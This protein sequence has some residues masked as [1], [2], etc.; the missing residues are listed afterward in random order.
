MSSVIPDG[1]SR[2]QIGDI[3]TFFGGLTGKT[4]RDFG[5]GHPFLTYMQ[6][7]SQQTSDKEA[8]D[9]VCINEGEKQN[10]VA[11]GDILFTTSSET[12]DEIGMTDVFLEINQTPYLNSFCFGLRPIMPSSIDPIFAKYLFRG[13]GFREDI[14]PLA[15]GSTRFNFSK[16]NLAK[17]SLLIPSLP[18]QKEIASILVSV[19]NVIENAQKKINKLQDLK[20]ATMNELLIKGI[21]HT[22]FKDSH[23]GMIPKSWEV[24]SIGEVAANVTDK[25]LPSDDDSMVMKYIGLE[26]IHSETNRILEIGSSTDVIS[27]K[28]IF[29]EGDTLFGKLRPYLKKVVIAEFSGICSTD[30]LSIRPKINIQ[31]QFLFRVLSSDNTVAFAMQGA[32]GNIMPRTSWKQLKKLRFGL[33]S[34]SEQQRITSILCSIDKNIDEKKNKLIQTQSLKKS[35]MQDFLTGKARVTV[36]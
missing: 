31:P 33:P 32:A 7:Y 11:Y 28:T 35:L 24:K 34:L 4:A 13:E 9:Y 27:S 14:R 5:D 21:G 8:M 15:Q 36:N 26:H 18:E 20:K 6:V 10:T 3:G 12:P 23:F 25:F 16:G 2:I 1:W 30:I 19:D 17:I 29:K 22:E